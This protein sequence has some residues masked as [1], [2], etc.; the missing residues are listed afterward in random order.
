MNCPNTAKLQVLT[1]HGWRMV[2][3]ECVMASR[4]LYD[5]RSV[6]KLDSKES[7]NGPLASD[8]YRCE[9]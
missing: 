8:S 4:V 6:I 5:R 7:G 1:P 9:A 2:C 3:N